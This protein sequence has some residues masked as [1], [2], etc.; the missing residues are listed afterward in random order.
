VVAWSQPRY[1]HGLL[2]PLRKGAAQC[3]L[4]KPRELAALLGRW[5]EGAGL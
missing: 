1:Q 5:I 4:E 3:A 2:A